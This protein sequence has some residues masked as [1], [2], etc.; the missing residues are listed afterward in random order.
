MR[1]TWDDIFVSYLCIYLFR[2]CVKIVSII[3][4]S[5]FCSN[6]Q[7]EYVSC[8]FFGMMDASRLSVE[9]ARV[10]AY[11]LYKYLFAVFHILF[12]MYVAILVEICTYSKMN[13]HDWICATDT[14]VFCGNFSV[15][16]QT[17]LNL[18]KPFE[19]FNRKAIYYLIRRTLRQ[20]F[21]I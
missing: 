10:I 5:A 8:I 18:T 13:L 21:K 4:S 20:L 11:R 2:I 15:L 1:P 7:F 3:P 14:H 16:C 12:V 6:S 17:K 9:R 19:L